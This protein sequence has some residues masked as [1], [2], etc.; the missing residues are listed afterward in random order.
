MDSI[1]P[2]WMEKSELKE[3]CRNKLCKE[4]MFCYDTGN[5]DFDNM[6]DEKIDTYYKKMKE[7]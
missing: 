2:T 3:Y 4:C 1:T 6:S 5:C 7:R